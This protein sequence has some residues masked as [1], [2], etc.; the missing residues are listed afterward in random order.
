MKEWKVERLYRSNGK[1]YNI[2]YPPDDSRPS[3]SRAEAM[4][5]GAETF[6]EA[7]FRR[8]KDVCREAQKAGAHEANKQTHKQANK[9]RHTREENQSGNKRKQ[10]DQDMQKKRNKERA[11]K[12]TSSRSK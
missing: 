8:T 6:I 3:R 7:P 11:I 9:H 5:R 12:A 2:F 1:S 4:R 10:E